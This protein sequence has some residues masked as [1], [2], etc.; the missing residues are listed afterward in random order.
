M[1]EQDIV[2]VQLTSIYSP[3]PIREGFMSAELI[4]AI[5]KAIMNE[6]GSQDTIYKLK[7]KKSCQAERHKA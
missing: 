6:R 7:V 5:N 1:S 3:K 4:G 2:E